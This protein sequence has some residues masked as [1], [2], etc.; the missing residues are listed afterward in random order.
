MW[1]TISKLL[2]KPGRSLAQREKRCLEQVSS[3]PKPQLCD[4]RIRQ[5]YTCKV[6]VIMMTFLRLLY[7][8]KMST[9]PIW[10]NKEYWYE[11]WRPHITCLCSLL[12]LYLSAVF[13]IPKWEIEDKKRTRVTCYIY[14][15]F[16]ENSISQQHSPS[17]L[18]LVSLGWV[19]DDVA[20]PRSQP[21]DIGKSC[22]N[23]GNRINYQ[24][25]N[26]VR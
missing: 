9:K 2:F 3:E 25:Y 21:S 17:R 14:S 19:E 10:P 15:R 13:Q 16:E 23:D 1:S 24:V 4:S 18:G 22:H 5:T 8:T 20:D 11:E 6:V 12:W 26:H 7:S